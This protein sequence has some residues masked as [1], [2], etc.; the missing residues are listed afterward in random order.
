M[1][2]IIQYYSIVSLVE[3]RGLALLDEPPLLERLVPR[4][5]EEGALE[6][7]ALAAAEV[8]QILQNVRAVAARTA[9]GGLCLF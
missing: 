7:R 6:D 4:G 2:E 3:P 8:V 5:Q 9:G 1:G